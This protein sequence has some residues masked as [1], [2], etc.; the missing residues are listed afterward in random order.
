MS[1]LNHVEMLQHGMDSLQNY[2][3]TVLRI[4]SSFASF[5]SLFFWFYISCHFCFL[6]FVSLRFLSIRILYWFT[7]MLTK[8]K[9]SVFFASKQKECHFCF[10]SFHFETKTNDAP[11]SSRDPAS[12]SFYSRLMVRHTFFLLLG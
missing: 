7:L 5:S 1:S 3:Y 12:S 4:D 9:N 2:F 10:V 6:L 8:R 11:Y